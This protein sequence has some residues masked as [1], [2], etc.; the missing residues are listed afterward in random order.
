VSE[1]GEVFTGFQIDNKN[2]YYS[3]LGVRVPIVR[4]SG[5]LDLFAQATTAGYGYSFKSNG[6]LLDANVQSIVPSLGITKTIGGW[7][8]SAL[9]GPQLRRIEEQRLNASSTIAHQAGVYGQLEAFYWQEKWNLLAI[10]SYAD[11]DNF[12]WSRLRGKAL[13][14]QPE[15]SCCA[16]YVGWDV[17][18]MGSAEFRG[19]MTGPV[20]E[21]QVGNVFVLA[22]GGYQH[23]TSFHSGAYGGFEIYFPF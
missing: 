21:V 6:Q 15:K 17:T 22:R 8:L 2:Q 3:Y 13:A 23:S 9:A 16:T 5:G 4:D 7:S 20:G 14:Y 10:G 19:V 18:G 1:A 12:F 11:L